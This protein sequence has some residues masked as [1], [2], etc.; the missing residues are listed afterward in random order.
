M[1]STAKTVEEYLAEVPKDRRE[2]IKAVRQQ[3]LDNLPEGYEEAMNWG[4][5]TYGIPLSTHSGTYNGQ[6]LMFAAI[7]NQ[8]NYMALY[9]TPPYMTPAGEKYSDSWLQEQYQAAGKKLDMGKSCIRFKQLDD[10]LLDPLM[11]VVRHTPVEKMIGYYET[12]QEVRK[13]KAGKK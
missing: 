1:Q 6:P 5:I 11:E 8:K 7:A 10:L 4:M 2:A 9:I 3:I 12:A 13:S